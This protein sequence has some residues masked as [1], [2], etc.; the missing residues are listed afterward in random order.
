MRLYDG[1]NNATAKVSQS[2]EVITLS[3]AGVASGGLAFATGSGVLGTERM[4]IDSSGKVGIGTTTPDGILTVSNGTNS[5]NS[6]ANADRIQFK[7]AGLNYIQSEGSLFLQPDGDLVLNGTGSEIMRLK[8]GN[9]LVGHTTSGFFKL[10]V[11]TTS[12]AVASFTGAT[13]AYSDFTDGTTTLRLQTGGSTGAVGTVGNHPLLFRTNNTERMRIDN[14]GNV[15]INTSSPTQP[16]DVNGNINTAANYSASGDSY[17]YSYNGASVGAVRSGIQF[18]GS[19][20]TMSFFTAQAE[21]MRINSS[22]YV[23]I[24]TTNPLMD[25]H[26]Q[27]TGDTGIQITKSG[28]VAA[29]VKTVAGALFFGVDGANGDTERLRI[30]SS[31]DLRLT[32]SNQDIEFN[33]SSSS[34]V[35]RL[36]WHYSGGL[37]SW[38]E[39]DHSSGA[40]VFGNQGS[41][42]MRIDSSG[43]VG[44]NT[45]SPSYKLDVSN[46]GSDA[47]RIDAGSDFSGLALSSTAGT[48][49]VRTSTADALIFYNVSSS[50]EMARFDSNQ[51]FLLGQTSPNFNAAGVRLQYNGEMVATRDGGNI[52]S[53]NRLTNDGALMNFAQAGSVEG[54]I[55]VSGTTISYNGAHLSR[56]FQTPGVDHTT[57]ED[58]PE[59]LRG[60][61]LT[62]LDEMCEWT[63]EN[64]EQLNKMEVSS[65]RGDRNVAGVFQAWDDDDDTYLNDGYCAMTGDFVIRIAA[66]CTVQRGDLLM[67]AGD[68]TACP[69]EGELADVIRSCTV[70][71]VTSTTVSHTYDD[72]SYL[73]PCVLMAC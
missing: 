48:W 16:L 11:E 72:G 51:Y 61:V 2:G 66:D 6:G 37:Q 65:I 35:N 71:K 57:I 7:T 17:F 25:L 13:N 18:A 38:I 47:I 26:L 42:R 9:V 73:V 22:G 46:P 29:R 39:R 54:S 24:G 30:D 28:S 32:S 5:F 43:N 34:H 56:W 36:K 62:N 67:S 60:S 45:T 53:L 68:G 4:R 50:L 33:A 23:G 21:R 69:Q 8:S 20:N 1:T 70:A 31:G 12:T 40:F 41:E 44:I 58:R 59:I 14:S 27:G 19:T 49:A 63:N 15:G 10:D 55:S 52:V 3:H 64:N